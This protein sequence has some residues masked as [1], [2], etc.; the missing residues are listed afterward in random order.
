MLRRLAI[1]QY[2]LLL[3]RVPEI[4]RERTVNFTKQ[5]RQPAWVGVF[6]WIFLVARGADA[7][8]RRGSLPRQAG[9]TQLRGGQRVPSGGSRLAC[10]FFLHLS[11]RFSIA[12]Y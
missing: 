7:G 5:K 9:R 10:R 11:P 3:L 8:R 6:A 12:S 2:L 4:D 1:K